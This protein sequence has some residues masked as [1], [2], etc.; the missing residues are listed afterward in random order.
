MSKK[1]THDFVKRHFDDGGYT[2]LDTYIHSSV[3][4]RYI[5]INNHRADISWDNWNSGKRCPYCYGKVRLTYETVKKSFEDAGYVL[6]SKKYINAHK[7][8]KYICP[9]KH[10]HS[11]CWS[12]WKRGDRCP[13]C[14]GKA[15]FTHDFVKRSFEDA[16][17]V[18]LSKYKNSLKKLHYI[19]PLGHKSSMSF[20]TW[21]KGHRCHSCYVINSLIGQNNPSWRGGSSFEPYCVNWTSEFKNYVKERDNYMCMNPDCW[22]TSERLSVHHIDYNKK[23]CTHDNIITLCNSCNARANTSR[24]WHKAWYQAIMYRRYGYQYN[25]KTE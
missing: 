15:P 13:Y 7:K 14:S 19:C 2:L 17:Y 8:L 24:R 11:I 16:G 23:H 12:N 5:C 22:R 3:K 21:K 10:K 20:S 18:L 1:L 6:L 25:N 9:S 4:M